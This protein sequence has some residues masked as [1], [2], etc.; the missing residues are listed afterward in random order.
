MDILLQKCFEYATCKFYR[1]TTTYLTNVYGILL[2]YSGSHILLLTEKGLLQMPQEE[3]M[4]IRPDSA[5]GLLFKDE[6]Y[7]HLLKECGIDKLIINKDSDS[8]EDTQNG[9]E[10]L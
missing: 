7:L 4:V 9:K 1:V 8:K 10:N 6:E 2:H 5:Y 3:I